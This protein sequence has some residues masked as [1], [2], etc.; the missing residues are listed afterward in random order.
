ML[1][2]HDGMVSALTERISFR[3]I[4]GTERQTTPKSDAVT[5]IRA[6]KMES[7][8]DFDLRM[9]VVS[10]GRSQL[11]EAFAAITVKS[12]A[13][14]IL[15]GALKVK[16]GRDVGR[17]RRETKLG[18]APKVRGSYGHAYRQIAALLTNPLAWTS[19]TRH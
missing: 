11:L 15:S 14:W 5:G 16:C 2:G 12:S 7:F 19:L 3:E 8:S 4:C 6:L 18:R 1:C 13:T 9:D 17:V 10:F